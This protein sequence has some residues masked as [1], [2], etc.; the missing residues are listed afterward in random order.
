MQ[1]TARATDAASFTE[2]QIGREAWRLLPHTHAVI[3]SGGAWKPYRHLK[4]LG[5]ICANTIANGGRL[6]VT[7]PPR[8]GKSEFVSHRL[9]AWYLDL[10]PDRKVILAGYS[11]EFARE[12][13]RK[14]RDSITG[15]E[16]SLSRVRQDTSSASFWETTKGGGMVAVG[17]GGAI[18]GRGGQVLIVDDPIKN[19]EEA[20]SE[21]YR[22]RV[23]EWFESVLVSRAHQGAAIIVLMTRWHPDDLAGYLIGKGGWT[24][25]NL[26][27]LAEAGDALGRAQGEALCPELFTRETLEERRAAMAAFAWEGLYQQR[28]SVPEGNIIQREWL[29]YYD[30]APTNCQ[31][32]IQS[33]DCAFKATKDSDFVVG[34]IW[35]RSK[36]DFYLLDQSRA[37]LSFSDTILAIGRLTARWP[38]A[39]AKLIEEKANGAG[40]VDAMKREVYG[41]IPIVPK[42]SK[43]ARVHTVSSLFRAGNIYIPRQASWARDFEEELC[44]FPYVSH[45]DQVDACTQALNHLRGCNAEKY[46]V[47]WS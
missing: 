40:V 26:P 19:F 21:I 3:A 9:P 1:A 32:I 41:L 36:A 17:I 30:V 46:Q 37:R 27:A 14:V 28:P 8:H 45:D 13:G 44:A 31:T 43:I 24:H 16:G 22:R 25:V 23:R 7:L 38:Q 35:G 47:A 33:W 18:T 42:D 29:R 15:F 34:Q 2:A 39:T 11:D 6:L 10:F 20:R 4:F 5:R 12:W